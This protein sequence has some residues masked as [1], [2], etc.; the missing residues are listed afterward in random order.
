IWYV[1]NDG[2]PTAHSVFGTAPL[3]IEIQTTI[4][5]FDRPDVFGDM[6]FIKELIINK[7]EFDIMDTYIGLW[8]DPDLGDAGDDFV[9][10][11]TTLGL[12]ICYND[13][14]DHDYAGFSGGTP[15]VGY[16]FFQGPIIPSVG[17]TAFALGRKIPDFK[18]MDM[19]SFSKYINTDDPVWSDP[20]DAVEMYNLMM[21]K[22]KDGTEF[23]Y[24]I[25]GGSAYAHPGDP[26][27]DTGPTD[28]E[29]V[30]A[31][32]NPSEDRRFLM[33]AGPFTMAVG[34]TQEVVFGI[35]MA[36]AGGPMASYLYL[37]QVD[38]LAQ[39]AYDIQFALPASPE[40]P[41]VTVSSFADHM[42]LTWD[43]AQESYVAEDVIDKLP[44]PV[45]YDTTF[46]TDVVGTITTT[47]DTVIVGTDTTITAVYDTSYA[48]VQVVD[49][50]DTTFE[51]E[52][53][54]FTFEGYNVYQVET[55][56]GSGEI[57]RIAT[58][59]LVNGIT[60][61]FDNVFDPNLGETINRRVQFGSNSGIKR[62]LVFDQDALN[63][64]APLKM[65][66][67]YYLAVLA[68]GYNPYGIPRTLES[69]M[70]II[71]IRPQDKLQW[72]EEDSTAI[73]GDTYPTTHSEG[74]SDG[75]V[76]ITIIDPTKLTGDDYSVS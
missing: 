9:G 67:V 4:F 40:P 26:T 46:V 70:R 72:A 75:S 76:A 32:E 43:D 25:T 44:V 62:H 18:N 64:N 24:S 2:D 27:K 61:I 74:V 56:S 51:G 6:M 58:F 10:C 1:S 14:V 38:A 30:D 15:A 19:T 52:N 29:F 36:A 48:W 28:N 31:D 12:G 41:E 42:L 66:R 68:Y 22:M 73:F 7:G 35:F 8:S 17:D 39:L 53:T 33:N 11:D 54:T 21:G 55:L 50:I 45:A 47:W 69:P 37:K 49:Q 59:D 71:A 34:D 13:G 20:N 23:A 3:G 57:K 5:G 63:N 60:E 65:N 16:D